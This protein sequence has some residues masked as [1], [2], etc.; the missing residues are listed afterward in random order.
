M[1]A[2]SIMF[3][4]KETELQ[5]Q[6][7]IIKRE[8]LIINLDMA[9]YAILKAFEDPRVV[10]QTFHAAANQT[11]TVGLLACLTD[12][13]TPCEN[14]EKDLTVIGQIPGKFIS[15]PNALSNGRFF[16]FSFKASSCTL[17]ECA[18]MI[19]QDFLCDTYET[20]AT[21][22][23]CVYRLRTTWKP[24]CPSFGPCLKPKI[25][26]MVRLETNAASRLRI[27][28]INPSRYYVEKMF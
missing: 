11:G 23:D 14:V 18:T 3:Y 1:I 26:W 10:T 24:L 19:N 9:R 20:N 16:G 15:N 8:S 4:F 13:N 21:A 6:M 22:D 27:G 28:Q 17:P 5:N 25:V 7:N 12:P 2:T